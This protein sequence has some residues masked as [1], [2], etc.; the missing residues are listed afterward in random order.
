MT[1]LEPYAMVPRPHTRCECTILRDIIEMVRERAIR[2]LVAVRQEKG[3]ADNEAG[4]IRHG[5]ETP[6]HR[7]NPPF[8]DCTVPQFQKPAIP[9]VGNLEYQDPKSTVL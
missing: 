3:H 8:P 4:A 2:R 9:R 1:K 7:T 6:T 5:P